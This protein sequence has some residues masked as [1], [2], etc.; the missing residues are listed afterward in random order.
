MTSG[1]NACAETLI[2]NLGQV[3]DNDEEFEVKE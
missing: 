3:A 2:H 1:V